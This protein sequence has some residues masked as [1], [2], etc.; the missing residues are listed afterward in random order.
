MIAMAFPTPNGLRAEWPRRRENPSSS[1]RW[2][3]QGFLDFGYPWQEAGTLGCCHTGCRVGDWHP[4]TDAN[5]DHSSSICTRGKSIQRNRE[6]L[7]A[8]YRG[9]VTIRTWENVRN[10]YGV[11]LASSSSA[12]R[13]TVS[14]NSACFPG[15]DKTA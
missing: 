2:R 1:G 10:G 15:T 11:C 6:C 5:Y 3:R 4:L 8:G 9:F 13:E 12:L 14:Y 7:Q